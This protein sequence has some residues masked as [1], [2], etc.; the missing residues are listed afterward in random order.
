[1][2]SNV[3]VAV[4]LNATCRQTRKIPTLKVFSR[5]VTPEKRSAVIRDVSDKPE[6]GLPMEVEASQMEA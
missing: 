4:D 5:R 6:L 1:M 3:S 2:G